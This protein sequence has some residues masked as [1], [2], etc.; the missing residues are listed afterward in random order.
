MANPLPCRVGRHIVGVFRCWRRRLWWLVHRR[1]GELC[2]SPSSRGFEVEDPGVTTSRPT[3]RWIPLFL[4]ISSVSTPNEAIAGFAG[5]GW[6]LGWH[7]HLCTIATTALI[8][9]STDQKP[10][11]LELNVQKHHRLT[12]SATAH[13]PVAIA[14]GENQAAEK[15]PLSPSG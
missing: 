4:R 1:C 9:Y 12:P 15:P 8:L 14:S 11:N 2:R 7:A 13:R 3:G 6:D 10:H 5:W